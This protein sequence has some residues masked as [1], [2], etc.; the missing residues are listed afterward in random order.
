MLTKEQFIKKISAD[1]TPVHKMPTVGARYLA[2]LILSLIIVSGALFL[3]QSYRPGFFND[4][5]SDPFYFVETVF[6]FLPFLLA[7]LAALLLSVPGRS[8]SPWLFRIMIASGFLFVGMTV[9]NLLTQLSVLP[10][11]SNFHRNCVVEILALSWVP[12][13]SLVYFAS[14]GYAMLTNRLVLLVG[15]AGA[16]LPM[17]LMQIACVSEP[18]HNLLYHLAPAAVACG[19]F[20]IFGEKILE[21]K[22]K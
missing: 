18:G 20:Y 8:V 1:L 7:G 3:I 5:L 6:S 12:I 16:S 9:F 10:H 13:L 15:A 2:W 21:Y 19:L 22:R 14:Q 11:P 17:A 4:L